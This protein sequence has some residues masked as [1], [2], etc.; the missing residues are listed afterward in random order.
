MFVH[1]LVEVLG[2]NFGIFH[3][4]AKR[5]AAREAKPKGIACGG[6]RRRGQRGEQRKA[7]GV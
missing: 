1:F 4:I 5:D 2:G 3:A 6:G 7:F